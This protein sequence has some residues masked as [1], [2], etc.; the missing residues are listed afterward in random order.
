MKF[1]LRSLATVSILTSLLVLYVFGQ[2]TVFRVSYAIDQKT[3]MLERRSEDYRQMRYAVSQMKAP[4]VLQDKLDH[5]D[6]E[7]LLPREVRVIRV[8]AAPIVTPAM[9]SPLSRDPLSFGML[10]FFGRWVKVAQAKTQN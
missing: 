7:L 2:V 6:L 10:D 9:V 8:P 3:E 4:G 1:V 5:L